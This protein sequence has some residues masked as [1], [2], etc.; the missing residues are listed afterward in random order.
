MPEKGNKRF[1]I[2]A[3]CLAKYCRRVNTI[4]CKRASKYRFAIEQ[5]KTIAVE[6][7]RAMDIVFISAILV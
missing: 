7:V 2:A 4:Y 5:V 1:L 3:L 6:Q